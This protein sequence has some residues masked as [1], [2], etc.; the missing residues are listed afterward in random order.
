MQE[1]LIIKGARE[2]NLK[3]VDLEVP[4]NTLT[5]FTGLSGS[6]KTSLAF[7]TIYA[8]GQ[9]RYV[10]SLSSY[11]RQFLGLMEKPDVDSIDG[12]SPAI[13]IDQKT[14][15]KNPR[16]TVGTVTEIYD[17]L[18]LLYANIG[19]PHCPKCG[20]KISMQ[21]VDQIVDS[22]MELEKGTKI[23]VMAP[24]IR[25][26]KGEHSKVIENAIKDGYVRARIDGKL[27]DL[28]EELP[29]IERTKAHNIE[30]VVDRLVVNEDM[31]KI[32]NNVEAELKD[33]LDREIGCFDKDIV[34]DDIF[35]A[36]LKGHPFINF[37]HQVQLEASEADFSALSL[38]DS[39]IG[40]KKNVSIRDILINYPYPNTLMVLK[41][42]GDKLKEA[43]EKAATYFSIE[44]GKIK[45]SDSFLI[46]KVQNYNY[47]MFGGLD[48]E[49][50]LSRD[51]G[52]RV[53]SMKKDGKDIDLDKY[54]KVVMNN[55]RATNTS[56]YP[57]YEGAEVIK[58]INV[59][60]SELIINYFLKHHNV[61][62]IQQSNYIIK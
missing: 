20:K 10:E 11:A 57:S 5:V 2:N 31:E 49:I 6:G 34:I 61:K 3:N 55:Y 44:D 9:R 12:L 21:T 18:R 27:Y 58:E 26:K 48:Y 7:D 4:R 39:A 13:S 53:I 8:E 47:D 41:V 51:F 50:D 40:F 22:I 60:V 56:I 38:F 33:Y 35:E 23:L 29:E 16:S 28:A 30:I 46:P 37:L 14:T 15:S 19:V 43:I 59:D 17:Y 1:K 52:N 45:I 36:R 62:V 54:Y 42:K 25:G 24:V 32:F